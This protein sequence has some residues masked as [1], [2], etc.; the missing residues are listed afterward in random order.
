[1]KVTAG[2]RDTLITFQAPSRTQDS[3]TG[4]Y[5]SGWANLTSNPTEWAEVR[6]FLPSRG[7]RVADGID[8][9]RRPCRIRCLARQDITSA[10]RVKIGERV[11]Q[12]VTEPA[13]IGDRREWI[14]FIAEES[15]TEGNAP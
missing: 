8:L 5:R 11:L 3:E 12:I 15:S 4:A 14:E 10:M 13:T 2:Q 7:E 1:M 9:S 6:D